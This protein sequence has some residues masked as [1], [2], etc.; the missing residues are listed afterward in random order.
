MFRKTRWFFRNKRYGGWN[1]FLANISETFALWVLQFHFSRPKL[2]W[3]MPKKGKA[4][5][6]KNTLPKKNLPSNGGK[7][8]WVAAWAL[9][10]WQAGPELLG[11]GRKCHAGIA[12]MGLQVVCGQGTVA[13]WHT[14]VCHSQHTWG[15]W[16]S[17]SSRSRAWCNCGTSGTNSHH[18]CTPGNRRD[19]S[20]RSGPGVK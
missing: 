7:Q 12:T 13:Q 5:A 11:S 9:F 17:W 4:Q 3:S 20:T 8:T 16:R 2:C 10:S 15:M 14:R 1:F 6:K 19:K 18:L